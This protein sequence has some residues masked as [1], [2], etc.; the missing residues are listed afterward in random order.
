M[1]WLDDNTNIDWWTRREHSQS[2]AVTYHSQ[3]KR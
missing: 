3:L 2:I 1:K